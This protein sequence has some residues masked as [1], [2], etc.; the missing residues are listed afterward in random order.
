MIF[1]WFKKQSKTVDKS[2]CG[3]VCQPSSAT[4][5]KSPFEVVE[6]LTG[7]YEH[8]SVALAR[9]AACS[10]SALYY[11]ADIY[12][13]F[14]QYWCLIDGNECESLLVDDD[15]NEPQLPKRARAILLNH[16]YLVLGPVRG[17]EWVPPGS[18]VIEG[19]PW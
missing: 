14:W 19:A 15:P 2:Q 13:D 17:F 10:K 18:P 8:E 1:G 7:V 16:D 5:I 11:S 3:C 9:C 4:L 12:D 6:R